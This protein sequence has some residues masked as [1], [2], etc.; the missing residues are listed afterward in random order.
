MVPFT[1]PT[2]HEFEDVH[3][4]LELVSSGIEKADRDVL[5]TIVLVFSKD[6]QFTL[7]SS[8]SDTERVLALLTRACDNA[9]EMWAQAVLRYVSGE[10]ND[11][12]DIPPAA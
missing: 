12:G 2:L 1:G 10:D 11:G 3:Q 7:H 5:N 6:G 8:T 4:F 9:K